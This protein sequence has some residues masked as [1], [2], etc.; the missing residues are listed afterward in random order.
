KADLIHIHSGASFLRIFHI[1]IGRML[2]KKIIL[3][4]HYY[5]I[6]K[7]KIFKFIDEVFYKLANK[8][9]VVNS[10]ILQN[11]SVPSGKCII[12]NAFLPPIMEE[13]P[14]LPPNIMEWL[15]NE[16][17][18]R[19]TIVCANAWRLDLFNNHDLYGLDMCIEIARRLLDDKFKVS[20][21]FSVATIDN[22]SNLYTKYQSLIKE[23]HLQHNFLLVSQ[24][25]SFVRLIQEADIVLRPTNWDGDSLT[26]REAL[27][28]GKPTLA[29]DIVERPVGTSVFKTRD[30][31]DLEMK[32]KQMLNPAEGNDSSRVNGD[33]KA[34]ADFYIDLTGKILGKNRKKSDYTIKLYQQ[35]FW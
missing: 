30:I 25:L 4:L 24:D 23:L 33:N 6:R 19:K 1:I 18:L 29:S 28:L 2:R 13:E 27:M 15:S 21:V 9:I 16:K 14:Q 3:T 31:V 10:N 20:F 17:K 32:L 8:I 11:V 22:F 7:N 26:V 12:H 35:T 5:P 34:F